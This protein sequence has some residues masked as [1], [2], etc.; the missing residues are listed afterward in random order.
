VTLEKIALAARARARKLAY[1]S[2]IEG[3]PK[4][5]IAALEALI[6]ID[7]DEDRTPLTWLREWS[8]APARKNLAG[9]VER[10]H[11]I[12][13]LNVRADREKRIHRARYAAIARETAILSAQ[14][15]SRFDQQRRLAT[16]VVFVREMEAILTDAGIAMFDKMLG[17]VFRQGGSRAQGTP[18]R[19]GEGARWLDPRTS[20]DGK[21]HV[22]RQ[23]IRR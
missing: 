8:E 5:A 1:R 15:L 21:S 13:T 20:W 2:L 4:P 10:L 14:H 6:V 12:R 19:S 7:G 23:G 16:L 9:I 18:G 22:S 3:L 11:A 17:S